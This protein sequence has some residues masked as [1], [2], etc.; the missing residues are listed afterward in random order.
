MTFS[1][2]ISRLTA[3]AL[4][5]ATLWMVWLALI[6]PLLD[7]L[8]RDRESIAHSRQ[9]AARYA[10]SAALLP[11]LQQRLEA[12][13]A[14]RAGQRS[15]LEGTNPALMTAALQAS[16]Q[17][18]AKTADVG[19]R[20]SRTLPAAKDG[21]FE[22]IGLDL[23]LTASAAGLQHLLY[24]LETAEPV[25]FVQKLSVRVPENG[26]ATMAADGQPAL[27]VSLR[28]FSYA[29]SNRKAP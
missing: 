2:M 17:Q 19:L 9:L 18:L 7:G 1:P 6:A 27:A 14:A 24:D 28:V 26:A 12:L 15:F 5:V 29:R 10:Q 25:I 4:L 3:V 16:T 20:S 11:K 22:Q 23:E 13:R 8:E 21:D